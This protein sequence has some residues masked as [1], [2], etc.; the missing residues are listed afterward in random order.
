MTKQEIIKETA[1]FY[2]LGNRGK[3]GGDTHMCQ[4]LSSEGNMCAVGRCIIPEKLEDFVEVY[5]SLRVISIS[6]LEFYLQPQYRGHSLAFWNDLQH[7]HDHPTN[8]T[9]EG[10]SEHGI[11]GR[12]L[13]ES[14]YRD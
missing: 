5:N 1:E 12:V 14:A 8:W 4:Y 9:E 10:L 2:N 13:L 3:N 11:Q 6:D 7:F